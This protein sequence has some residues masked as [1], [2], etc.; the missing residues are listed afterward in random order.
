MRDFIKS[1]FASIFAIV[2][3]V[4]VIA[5]VVAVKSSQKPKIK[6]GS[7]LVIDIYGEIFPYYPPGDV[8]SEIFG[9][10]PETLQ[11]ILTGL[12]MAAADK[13]IKGVILKLSS[14]NS[15][16]PASYQEICDAIKKVRAADKMV[17]A[18]SDALNARTLYMAAACDSIF[19]PLGAD[20]SF[21]GWGTSAMFVK[22][23]LDKLGIRPELHKIDEYKSAAELVT[24]ESMS[25]EARENREWLMDDG[26]DM[27][28]D[29]LSE[30]RGISRD[31]LVELMRVALFTAPEAKEAGLIDDV[32]YWHELKETLKDE[33]DDNL[34]T[35]SLATYSEYDRASV[36]L[37]GKKTIAVVHAFGSI[38]GRGNR[39][40]PLL[41]VMM[42]H[43]SVSAE[44]RR[45]RKDKDV[46]AVVFRVESGGG[47][48][49]ASDLIGHE[50]EILASEKPVVTSMIDV[51]ASGGYHI[52]YKAD[53]IVAD[54]FTI[55]GSIGSITGK[56]N[57]RGFYQ[58]LGVTFD[59]VTR[60]PNALFWSP[61]H[62]FSDEQRRILQDNHW[63]GFN[64]WMFDIADKR[65]IPRDA[66][67]ELSM[68][69]V[70]TGRQ[71]ADNGLVDEVGGLDRAIALAK[72]L[73]EIPDDEEVNIVH[74]PKKKGL[75]QML[76]G[77]G[78]GKAAM[79]WLAYRFIH[80]DL[81][82]SYRLLMSG[83]E[84][85]LDG[86]GE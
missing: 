9:G 40:D 69:R 86:F 11:R 54:P 34:R 44:L 36:G 45:V 28:L 3:I 66:I 5:A 43:E 18:F 76:T 52:A 81:E 72:E 79:S 57:T 78:G 26:W 33:D 14:N 22:G 39:V 84:P 7:Y 65:G 38:G 6:D 60:G 74:Y 30:G 47:E 77:G 67:G 75:L 35:V 23:T 27:L 24:R 31:R 56:M 16:G 62:S 4:A 21:L 83:Y 15:L 13:R 10:E 19:S 51:A 82:A 63:K 49:L 37:K 70:W 1:V 61:L 42:G 85:V 50:V 32:R 80:E 25:P 48:S 8:M 17:Y 68:G 20:M 73:A 59:S 64:M 46:K 2:L 71:A 12:D 41:G 58:K 29:G 55:T 53:R